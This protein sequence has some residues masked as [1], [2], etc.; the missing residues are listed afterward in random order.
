MVENEDFRIANFS[1]VTIKFSL[2]GYLVFKTPRQ[3]LVVESDMEL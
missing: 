3:M 1:S 2:Q